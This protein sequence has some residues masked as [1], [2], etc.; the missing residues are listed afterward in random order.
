MVE[1]SKWAL[2]NLS[3]KAEILRHTYHVENV[4][5]VNQLRKKEILVIYFSCDHLPSFRSRWQNLCWVK[6]SSNTNGLLFFAGATKSVWCMT[7][8]DMLSN[9]NILL[10]SVNFVAPERSNKQR[11]LHGLA[12]LQPLPWPVKYK[13][14][15]TNTSSKDPTC[16]HLPYPSFFQ[17]NLMAAYTGVAYSIQPNAKTYPLS[18]GSVATAAMMTPRLGEIP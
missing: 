9:R 4:V 5:H 15:L 7:M 2:S 11:P 14:L 16:L 10:V 12:F 13:D 18:I 1:V 17:A 6:I 8:Y 3:M